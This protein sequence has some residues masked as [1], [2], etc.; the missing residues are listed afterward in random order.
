MLDVLISNGLIVDGTASPG[1]YGAVGIQGD[2]VRILR[3]DVSEVEAARV[4]DASGQV[5]CPGFIDLHSH[6]GHVILDDPRHEPKIRQGVTT[7]LIGIDGNSF[8]PF[9]SREDLHRFIE[10]DAGLNGAPSKPA[11]WGSVAEHLAMFDNKVAVNICYIIG[12]S[13]LRI[14]ALGWDNRPATGAEI[15]NMKSVLREGMEEGAFGMSTG[16][17][18]PPG[19]YANTDELVELSREAARLGGIYHT[20]VRYWLGDRFLDPMKE[21]IEIGQRSGVPVHITHL[22]QTATSTRGARRMLEFVEEHREQGMDLTFD[23]FPYAVGS[24]RV[25]IVFPQW[26][27]DGGPDKLKEVLRSPEARERLR[28]EVKP[29]APTWEE[30]WLTNFSK[31]H[32]RKYDGRSIAE[33]ADMMNLHAVDALCELLLDESLQLS[34][35]GSS[36]NAATVPLFMSHPLCLVGSDAVMV[37]EH[38]N[39]HTYG[40]FPFILSEYVREERWMSL[41][42]AIRKMTSFAAQRLGLPDRGLL[43]DGMKA[44]VVVFDAERVKGPATRREPKQFPIGINYVLVNG[45]LVVD[46]NVHT[47][48]LPGR[49]L[50]RGR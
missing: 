14:W 7:E 1:F 3:G 13:P 9:K 41:A 15:E 12:N 19:S 48:A 42:E 4:I 22:S 50:R 31:H 11:E 38:P 49:A 20:H 27:H 32:N 46:N 47:G 34:Y 24:T 28:T 16:L 29:R 33:V 30:M 43:R 10:L 35:T 36:R 40:T 23:T 6:G 44:D 25:L 45:K 17:D 2:E 37:G 21:A 26:A 39:P 8:A 18:Y 5:V